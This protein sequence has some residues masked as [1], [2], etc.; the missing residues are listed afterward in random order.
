M[1]QSIAMDKGTAQ[2]SE[3]FLA[4][5]V[6]GVL[7]IMILPVP[8]FLLDLFFAFNIA[9]SLVILLVGMYTLKPLEF[10]IFPTILLMATLLR[11]SL[12]V[13][14]TKLIL[15][16]GNEGT[17][18]AGAVIQSFGQF[19]IGG[20]YTVGLVVFFI[21]V[22]INFV[23]ITKGAGRIAEV[24]ARFTLDAMPGKQ[25]SIDA[26]LNAGVIN[27]AEARTR[28]RD[29]SREADFYGAM[30]G[31]SKFVRG[32]AIAGII[33]TLINIIGGLTIG[34]FQQGLDLATAAENY[35]ILSVGDGLLSQIPALIISTATGIVVTRAAADAHLGEETFKQIVMNPQA[36]GMT[37][38]ILFMFGLVPGMPHFPFLFLGIATATIAYMS[39]KSIAT[40]AETALKVSQIEPEV[41][42]ADETDKVE[43]L[44][45]VD[46]LELNIGYGLIPLVDTEQGGDLVD[47]IKGVRRQ[48]AMELGIIVPPIHI[49]DNLDL[50]PNEYSVYI[51]G[52]VIGQGEL[53]PNFYM[54][55]NPGTVEMGIDGI[56]AKEPCFGLD[57]IWINEK[58]RER[59]TMLGYTVVDLSTIIATH[60]NEIIRA[61]ASELIGRQEVQGL[62]DN[63]SARSP[64][65]VEELIPE[66]LTLGALVKVLKNLLGERVSVKDIRTILETL[67]DY[68]ILTKDT[69]IL[70]EYVRAGLARNITHQYKDAD[71]TISVIGIDAQLDSTVASAIQRSNQG[72]YLALEPSMTRKIVGAVKAAVDKCSAMGL[73]PVMLCSP[74]S[75]PHI[76]KIVEAVVPN[77]AVLSPA[78]LIEGINIKTIDT[79]RISDAN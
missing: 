43:N 11:L 6:L 42:P 50:K 63:C 32:D 10:S 9:L 66:L 47:R 13:A 20:N 57:A 41:K 44:L 46:L 19:I 71:N 18:A 77:L 53:M 29:V 15:L 52:I 51:K 73:V 1:A 4:I 7:A 74:V 61:N 78:E 22:V 14:S 36:M 5:S 56:A 34:I 58:E 2:S 69:D 54:A 12:N 59:A 79:V 23:V 33:I 39:S 17:A 64:K 38:G 76:K 75:R 31:A 25:M 65:V 26:D 55:M 62:L 37:S 27:E 35:M 3:I 45:N 60:M 24:A 21:L 8:P 67:A 48:V 49:R 30:D 28:R 68:A 70:T 40:A 16:H 72:A